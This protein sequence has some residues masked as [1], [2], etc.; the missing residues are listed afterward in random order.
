MEQLSA[1]LVGA[2]AFVRG[3]LTQLEKAETEAERAKAESEA[4]RA[5]D[6]I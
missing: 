5:C 3:S 4:L 1:E 2:R 6:S